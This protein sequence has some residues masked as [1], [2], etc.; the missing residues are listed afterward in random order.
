MSENKNKNGGNNNGSNR[1]KSIPLTESRDTNHSNPDWSTP[2]KS[3][4]DTPRGTGPRQPKDS[5]Q[6]GEV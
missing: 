4:G 2:I 3:N 5:K 6:N 1:P